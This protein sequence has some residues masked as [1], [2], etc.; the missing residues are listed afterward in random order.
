MF[1]KLHDSENVSS[2]YWSTLQSL[3]LVLQCS[4]QAANVFPVLSMGVGSVANAAELGYFEIA[5]YG[6]KKLLGGWSKTG[7]LF[8]CLPT[9]F[10]LIT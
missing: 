3:I 1:A 4:L 8:I 6:L 10:F 5:S 2:N 7:L 9:H